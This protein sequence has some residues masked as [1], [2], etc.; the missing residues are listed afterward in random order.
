ML[1]I[2]VNTLRDR[3]FHHF[4]K[5]QKL[6]TIYRFVG[7]WLCANCMSS[8]LLPTWGRWESEKVVKTVMASINHQLLI[9]VGQ[10]LL[11]AKQLPD[12]ESFLFASR[13][14]FFVS[15]N[16]CNFSC[17][18]FETFQQQLKYFTRSASSEKFTSRWRFSLIYF[19]PSMNSCVKINSEATLGWQEMFAEKERGKKTI[20][21]DESAQET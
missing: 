17:L 6:I 4:P 18:F 10:I 3:I 20:S 5:M 16:C 1:S 9:Q 11:L 7:F 19:L 13:R 2:D 8:L 15:L 14:S 21:V 12:R